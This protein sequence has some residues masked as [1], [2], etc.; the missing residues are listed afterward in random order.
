MKF[1]GQPATFS[2]DLV[3]TDADCGRQSESLLLAFLLGVVNDHRLVD[4]SRAPASLARVPITLALPGA[5]VAVGDSRLQCAHVAP[6]THAHAGPG[7]EEGGDSVV[8][9][10]CPAA[11]PTKQTCRTSLEIRLWLNGERA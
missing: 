8:H 3:G 10:F 9:P 11:N 7:E 4:D 6:P 2:D 1:C 5:H